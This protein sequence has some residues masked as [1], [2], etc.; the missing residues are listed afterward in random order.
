MSAHKAHRS[1]TCPLLCVL[2]WSRGLARTTS[3][4]V[5]TQ[6]DQVLSQDPP[7][8]DSAPSCCPY[9][10]P[11]LVHHSGWEVQGGGSH[12]HSLSLPRLLVSQHVC[13]PPEQSPGSSSPSVGPSGPHNRQGGS[14]GGEFASVDLASF[15]D[16]LPRVLV[17]CWC[18][19]FPVLPS[20]VETF[21]EALVVQ[22]IFYQFSV[23]IV[24]HVEVFLKCFLGGDELHVLLLC[25]LDSPPSKHVCKC[26]IIKCVLR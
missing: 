9:L 5:S 6:L 3:Q 22:E 24:T 1:W 19:C 12:Q 20:F 8:Q 25:H 26:G 10:W 13:T 21:L 18:L 14:P 2:I 17:P 15:T 16:S 23:R 7:A 4:A 11:H